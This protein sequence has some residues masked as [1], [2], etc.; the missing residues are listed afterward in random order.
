VEHDGR[1]T[2]DR[3]PQAQDAEEVRKDTEVQ[4]PGAIQTQVTPGLILGAALFVLA[5]WLT[6]KHA[7]WLPAVVLIAAAA[8]NLIAEAM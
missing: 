7:L 6:E 8:A 4:T 1:R 2:E 3:Y 5:A